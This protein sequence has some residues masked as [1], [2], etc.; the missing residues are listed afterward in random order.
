VA[1]GSLPTEVELI[2]E[3]MPCNAM[4]VAQEPE[5]RAHACAYF[6]D[7]GTYHSYDY[8]DD[9]SPRDLSVDQPAVYVG[10]AYTVPEALSGCRKAPIL[11]THDSRS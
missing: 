10:R 11:S 3:L 8:S 1:E 5:G 4:R 7:W 6:R 9:G 2:Y